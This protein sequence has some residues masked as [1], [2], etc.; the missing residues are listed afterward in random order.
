MFFINIS[1]STT[2]IF[3]KDANWKK[4]VSDK[5]ILKRNSNEITKIKTV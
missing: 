5:H 2:K 3:N 1:K 4:D